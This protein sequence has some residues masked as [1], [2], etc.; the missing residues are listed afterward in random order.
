MVTVQAKF[1]NQK[2]QLTENLKLYTRTIKPYKNKIILSKIKW[3]VKLHV[4]FVLCTKMIHDLIEKKI[5]FK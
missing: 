5:D 2:I 3:K 4:P 1:K